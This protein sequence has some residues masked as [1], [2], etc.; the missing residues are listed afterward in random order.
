MAPNKKTPK[1]QQITGAASSST[2]QSYSVDQNLIDEE[3]KEL[4]ELKE[5]LFRTYGTLTQGT[6]S[7][8]ISY[9]ASVQYA[10]A[11]VLHIERN[12]KIHLRM[13][14]TAVRAILESDPKI[15][16]K[17]K[18]SANAI[19]AVQGII[20]REY[21]QKLLPAACMINDTKKWPVESKSELTIDCS[22]NDNK[23]RTLFNK[24]PENVQICAKKD[25]TG[26]FIALSLT[27][28]GKSND[29]KVLDACQQVGLDFINGT[30]RKFEHNVAVLCLMVTKV[31]G[32]RLPIVTCVP[33]IGLEGSVVKGIGQNAG[34]S[35]AE[36]I[37]CFMVHNFL[38][39]QNVSNGDP[40]VKMYYHL[41]GGVQ[42][43]Q[44][45]SELCMNCKKLDEKMSS[46][47]Y[48]KWQP[49]ST[50]GGLRNKESRSGVTCEVLDL[51]IFN[52]NIFAT[53]QN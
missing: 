24:I 4:K 40:E 14:D 10:V 25:S 15:S 52:A 48:N 50:L 53:V 37:S 31:K 43:E 49:L 34:A 39:N 7:S 35:H 11:K 30:Q 1:E 51:S 38:R 27:P 29:K 5:F 22:I 26:K 33:N 44:G 3:M 19:A 18:K 32:Y 41:F 20:E 16:A 9:E 6:Q 36:E 2:E 45:A 13:F 42:A 17:D 46:A 12:E 8:N 21:V 23:G 28:Y 47:G